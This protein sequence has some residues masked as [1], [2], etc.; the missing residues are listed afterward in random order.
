MDRQLWRTA[1]LVIGIAGAARLV[2][3]AAVPLV[4]DEAYY[5]EWS[6]RPASGYFDHPPV[7]AWF[8]RGGTFLLG[9]TPLGVRL[10]SVLAGSVAMLCI[11][12]LALRHAGGAAAARAAVIGATVP[13]A[14]VGLVLA[15]PDAPLLLSY[16]AGL[17]AL[18]RALQH[19]VGSR[20]S[21]GWWLAGGAAVGIGMAAKYT[22]VLLPMSVLVALLLRRTLRDR[23]RSPEPYLASLLAL[24]VFSPVVLWNARHDWI[25]FGFQ[26]R[27][28]LGAPSGTPLPRLLELLA[29]QIGLVTPIVF[30]LMAAAV[31]APLVRRSTDRT[32]TLAIVASVTFGF[33]LFSALR[34]RVEPNWPAPAYVAGIVLLATAGFGPRARAVLHGGIMLAGLFTLLVYIHA[35][36]PILPITPRADPIARAYG[37][38]GMAAAAAETRAGVSDSS[39]RSVWVAANRY[40][41]AAQLAF[42]LPGNPVVFSLNIE[43]R[44]N[45]YGLWPRLREVAAAGDAVVVVLDDRGDEHPVLRAL[46][47]HFDDTRPGP[48]VDLERAGSR[49]DSRKIW[50]LDG[51]RGS[52]PGSHSGTTG[53]V[54]DR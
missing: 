39:S 10:F 54:P 16:A 26:L 40:Q 46:A 42:H 14:A 9:D 44:P 53:S 47:P 41:D 29:G 45:Q 34:Q 6:R 8:I 21:Y 50:I 28:G 48:A 7:I 49:I 32:F 2:L 51:W 12:D 3:A 31:V 15:T 18:D 38:S 22:A 17:A 13:V 33:F 24:A 52:W 25:S 1:L 5:W 36:H 35:L 11:A 23:L 19:R 37:W 20:P 30:A 4:P 43:A 27:H